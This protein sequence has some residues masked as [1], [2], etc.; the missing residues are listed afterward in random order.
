M[1]FHVFSVLGFFPSL[2]G[3]RGNSASKVSGGLKVKPTNALSSLGKDLSKSQLNRNTVF[4]YSKM[5]A[6]NNVTHSLIVEMFK[7]DNNE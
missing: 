7:I 3:S 2:L 5:T 6:E 1:N 4:S